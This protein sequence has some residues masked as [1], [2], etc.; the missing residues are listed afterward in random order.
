M[1][2]SIAIVLLALLVP[3][4]AFVQEDRM[5]VLMQVLHAGWK[6]PWLEMSLNEMP[7]FMLNEAVMV[8]P[9][10]P[11]KDENDKKYLWNP[12][13]DA[14][15][16]F[17]FSESKLSIP[18]ILLYSATGKSLEKIVFTFEH[19][20][21]D[22]ISVSHVATYKDLGGQ[23]LPD[24]T[25]SRHPPVEVEYHWASVQEDDLN[26]G[27]KVMFTTTIFMTM[28]LMWVIL[29]SYDGDSAA[30]AAPP[31]RPSKGAISNKSVGRGGGGAGITIN[32]RR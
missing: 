1:L 31:R 7:R 27:V 23:T 9:V 32:K 19:D 18:A 24:L 26:L 25:S 30:V 28:G 15:I 16:S 20:A 22:V 2:L 29:M 12:E 8:R 21:Y 11:K 13:I 6:S 14:K 17:T 5:S 3:S 4:N 10:F